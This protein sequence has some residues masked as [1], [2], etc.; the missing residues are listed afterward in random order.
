MYKGIELK[1]LYSIELA[2][3][4]VIIVQYDGNI[5][6]GCIHNWTV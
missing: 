5:V 2:L 3:F 6:I 4:S 1:L